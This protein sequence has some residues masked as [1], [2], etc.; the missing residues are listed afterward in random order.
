MERGDETREKQSQDVWKSN[1]AFKL[2]LLGDESTCRTK[3]RPNSIESITERNRDGLSTSRWHQL[4]AVEKQEFIPQ[5][6]TQLCEAV[7]HRTLR[8]PQL[9]CCTGDMALRQ[10]KM[11]RQEVSRIDT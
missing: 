3:R 5:I 4:V 2:R 10:Q 8:H 6:A 1:R 11:E 7:A 9:L